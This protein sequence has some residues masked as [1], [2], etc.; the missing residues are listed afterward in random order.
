VRKRNHKRAPLETKKKTDMEGEVDAL[1]W[2]QWTNKIDTS[3]RTTQERKKG[4]KKIKV[5]HSI[6]KQ[7]KKHDC[8]SFVISCRLSVYIR[9]N[10]HFTQ[11]N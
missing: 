1:R 6:W 2:H 3:L 11:L 9:Q 10:E 5:I 4:D 7:N 8:H